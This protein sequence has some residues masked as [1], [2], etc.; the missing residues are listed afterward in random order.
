MFPASSNV[1]QAKQTTYLDRAKQKQII[2]RYSPIIFPPTGCISDSLSI[3]PN[4]NSR[5]P[6]MRHTSIS[7]GMK[8]AGCVDH[9]RLST[10]CS[11]DISHFCRNLA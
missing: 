11:I 6:S 7:A 1:Q 8:Q 3:M 5:R 10:A 4:K 2:G 9:L